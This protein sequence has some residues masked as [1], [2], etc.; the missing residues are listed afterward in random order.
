MD[1]DDRDIDGPARNIVIGSAAAF[2]GCS[3]MAIRVGEQ[4][5]S[6]VEDR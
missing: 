3:R 5:A 6:M 4:G 2:G 1:A